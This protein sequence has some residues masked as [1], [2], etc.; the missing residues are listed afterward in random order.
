VNVRCEVSS[1]QGRDNQGH[2]VILHC[3]SRR[4]WRVW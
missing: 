3:D 1:C 2:Y 4:C